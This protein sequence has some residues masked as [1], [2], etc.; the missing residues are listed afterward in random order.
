[1]A[2]QQSCFT[3]HGRDRRDFESLLIATDLTKR[4]LF[5]EFV[6]SRRLVSG[7][8]EELDRLGVSF[9]TLYPDSRACRD[10]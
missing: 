7:L 8:L 4:G 6:I 9:A 2:G 5:R 3:V 1:M 10:S